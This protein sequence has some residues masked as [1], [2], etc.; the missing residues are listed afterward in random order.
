LLGTSGR[1]AATAAQ[2]IDMIARAAALMK[3][4]VARRMKTTQT[5]VA[6][7]KQRA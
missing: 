2:V 3:A 1:S 4:Q 5:A 7:Q 6:K